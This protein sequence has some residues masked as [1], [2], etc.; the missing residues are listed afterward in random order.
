MRSDSAEDH[1]EWREYDCDNSPPIEIRR[2]AK[3]KEAHSERNLVLLININEQQNAYHGQ[4]PNAEWHMRE[5]G[6][7]IT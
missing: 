6:K 5:D 1:F 4:N 7:F 2:L 3:R